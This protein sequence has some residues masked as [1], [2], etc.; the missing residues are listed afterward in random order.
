MADRM[1]HFPARASSELEPE[2][3]PLPE[4]PVRRSPARYRG[5]AL[6]KGQH[7]A[8]P[9][10]ARGSRLNQTRMI[11]AQVE[12]EIAAIAARRQ[13]ERFG[14]VQAMPATNTDGCPSG[15]KRDTP[16]GVLARL[17]RAL[18]RGRTTR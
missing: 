14:R 7:D 2:F 6:V 18:R 12:Q 3:G 5:L 10:P 1:L 15:T 11:V 9:A 8:A 13:A 17:I 16:W 4:K